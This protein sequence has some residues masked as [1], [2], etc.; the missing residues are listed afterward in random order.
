MTE[1]EYK[2]V[3]AIAQE[4]AVIGVRASSIAGSISVRL[5]DT[6]IASLACEGETI[7]GAGR[8]LADRLEQI[9]REIRDVIDG[10]R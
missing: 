3:K 8:G 1:A 7:I 9:A 5:D 4:L 10:D 2:I 6:A